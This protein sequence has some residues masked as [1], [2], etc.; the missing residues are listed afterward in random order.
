MNIPLDKLA[1][2]EC[3]LLFFLRQVEDRY[4]VRITDIETKHTPAGRWITNLDIKYITEEQYQREIEKA[5]EGTWLAYPDWDHLLENSACMTC[6]A[7][8]SK[9]EPLSAPGLGH[10]ID[11]ECANNHRF[12]VS[13]RRG[14][15]LNDGYD[16][17][18]EALHDLS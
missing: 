10:I 11:L 1:R 17:F 14:L 8:W 7:E 12:R 5:A 16:L 3:D 2:I 9:K 13:Y 6:G 18:W 15:G 4:R